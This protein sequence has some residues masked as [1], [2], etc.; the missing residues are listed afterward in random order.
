MKRLMNHYL[1]IAAGLLASCA[2]TGS[3]ADL[4]EGFPVQYT[5]DFADARS[6]TDLTFSDARAWAWSE[7][8]LELHGESTYAPP[9]RSPLAM[10][11]IGDA[12]FDDFVLEVEVLQTG[13]EY[14]HRDLCLFFGFESPARFYYAHLATTPDE[15]AHNVFLVDGA[16]RRAIAPVAEKGVE[17]SDTWHLVRLSRIDGMIRV[18]FDDMTTPV[19]EASDAT[20]GAGRIGL[21]SFDDTGRFRNARVWAASMIEPEEPAFD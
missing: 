7:A 21:G 1:G 18:F 16:D 15:H 3:G 14:G 4:R 17:W 5:Q 8:S 10:A 9:H 2:A 13:R 6:L 11:L 19:I 12:L 20:L